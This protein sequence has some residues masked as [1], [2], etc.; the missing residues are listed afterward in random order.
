MSNGEEDAW[1]RLLK[2]NPADVCRSTQ[3]GFN[4][5]SGYYVLPLFNTAIFVSPADRS[6]RGDTRLAKLLLNELAYYSRLLSLRYLIDAKD[7]PLSGEL[8]NP[9][10]VGGGL[11]FE[12]GS[13]ILPLDKI[14]EIY[15]HN[16]D[17]FIWSVFLL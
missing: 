15:S 10:Q 1:L 4:E 6:I 17:E 9:R 13:H 3:A 5:V 16:I 7:K 2:L 11:I 8:I 12:R 14:L